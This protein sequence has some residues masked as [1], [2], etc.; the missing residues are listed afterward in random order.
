ML[1]IYDSKLV[2]VI[3]VFTG[4]NFQVYASTDFKRPK[5]GVGLW[6]CSRMRNFLD[7]CETETRTLHMLHG[8]NGD[9][10]ARFPF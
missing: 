5:L 2:N 1:P 7:P 3:P 10:E 4:S 8:I 9:K 6:E